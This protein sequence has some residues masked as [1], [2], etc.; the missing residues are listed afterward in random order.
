MSHAEVEDAPAPLTVREM[1][2]ADEGLESRRGA[3]DLRIQALFPALRQLL[4]RAVPPA[5]HHVQLLLAKAEILD[6]ARAQGR[7][8]LGADLVW[9]SRSQALSM[10]KV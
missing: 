10:F 4:A 1:E 7:L 3:V 5:A 6:E 8:S 9:N 2:V